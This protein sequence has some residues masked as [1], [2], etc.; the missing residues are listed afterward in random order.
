MIRS[1]STGK[2]RSGREDS[3]SIRFE[4]MR[5]IRPIWITR[6]SI[7]SSM[8]WFNRLLIG[9][10]LPFI[11]L[12]S[13]AFTPRIGVVGCMECQNMNLTNEQWW[14]QTTCP[15]YQALS[16]LD[17]QNIKNSIKIK[18]GRVGKILC[19]PTGIRPDLM[20]N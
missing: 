10:I 11:A 14:A 13:R 18:S 9:L 12:S 4:V 7:R 6:T 20:N 19:P 15:P 17:L 1:A 3:G 16:G 2:Q 8:D 5:N